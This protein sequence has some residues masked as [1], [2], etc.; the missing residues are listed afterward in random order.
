MLG[1]LV[2]RR[3]HKE[4]KARMNIIWNLI[5]GS[6]VFFTVLIDVL[7]MGVNGLTFFN[8]FVGTLSIGIYIYCRLH[9][10]NEVKDE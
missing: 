6:V 9:D 10:V 4:R 8:T 3:R 1:M 5:A 7:I 2:F